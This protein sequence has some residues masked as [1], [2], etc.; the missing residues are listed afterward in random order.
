[1]RIVV[2]ATPLLLRSAGVKT[3]TYNLLMHMRRMAGAHE[4]IAWPYLDPGDDYSHEKSIV[5]PA[6]TLARLLLLHA[7]NG[8]RL[9]LLDWIGTPADVF[10]TSQQLRN[11]PR[12]CKLSATIH[13]VTCWLLPETHSRRNVK[14]S[15]WFAEHVMRRADGLIAVSENTLRDAVRVLRVPQERIEAI[16]PGVS[17]AFF[18]AGPKE[19]RQVATKYGLSKPYALFVGTIEPRK[20]VGTLLDAW[21]RMSP[22]LRERFDLVA[23][24]PWGWGEPHTLERLRSSGGSVRYLGYIPEPDLPG[25][26][27][28]ARLLAYPSLYEG[29]GFPLAQAMAA[30]VPVVTS[31]V[32]SMPEV[33]GDGGILVDPRSP[34]EIASVL[35]RLLE[36][37]DLRE[38]LSERARA[39]ASLYSWETSAQ[40]S[41]AFFR[42][43]A[44]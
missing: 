20:N 18:Q 40:Q 8:A 3:Y 5:S 23:A 7:A 13:D 29:F 22:D 35:T 15:L 32:S 10:H 39:R 2:D 24:G 26:T 41:L 33:A 38:K 6:E 25:L 44:G 14:S 37:H 34:S 4:V 31:N 28:G 1:M 21:L 30:G 42:R 19:A 27:A 9:P 12:R 36:S 16:Y 43:L 17:P 11:P